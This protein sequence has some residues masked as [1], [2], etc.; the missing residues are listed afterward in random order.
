MKK[1]TRIPALSGLIGIG[2]A[3]M[4]MLTIEGFPCPLPTFLTY[5]IFGLVVGFLISSSYLATKKFFSRFQVYNEHLSLRMLQAYLVCT[6][7][8]FLAALPVTIL[9]WSFFPSRL[10]AF[11]TSLGVGIISVMICLA[12]EY[13]YLKDE[14]LRLEQKNKE[15]AVIEERNRIARELHDSV[16]QSLFGISLN[17]NTLGLIFQTQPERAKVL[18]EQ[19][20]EM[21]EEAQREMRLM[22]YE[23]QPAILQEKGFFEAL[24]ALYALFQTRY[25]LE[26]ISHISGDETQ[27]DPQIQLALYRVIQ[28]A[29]HNVVKHAQAT[30]AEVSLTIQDNGEVLVTIKDN[31]HGFDVGQTKSTG[32]FGLVGMEE[33]ITALNGAFFL[34]SRLGQGTTITVQIPLSSPSGPSC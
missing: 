32:H 28:E 14:R 16:S 23:L 20:K 29:L 24:E 18:I 10:I 27:V 4:F 11:W 6:L 8:F 7:T 17:L 34:H 9:P 21:V 2:I 26:I 1:Q 33:R 13:F 19:V 22:I 31:G 15:L 3:L 12:F 30:K 5:T 25:K